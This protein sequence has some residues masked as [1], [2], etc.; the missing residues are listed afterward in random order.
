MQI[1]FRHII[2]RIVGETEHVYKF[3]VPRQYGYFE[4]P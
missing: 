1:R 2:V 3:I 4:Q